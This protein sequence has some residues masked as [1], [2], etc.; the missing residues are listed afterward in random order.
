[1]IQVGNKLF[2]INE[3]RT[4]Q[5]H[6]TP[7]EVL[8]HIKS[9][10]QIDLDPCGNPWS[11]VEAKH[12]LSAHNN[13]NGLEISWSSYVNEGIVY[14][15]PPFASGQVINWVR[16]TVSEGLETVMLTACDPSTKWTR[17]TIENCNVHVDLSKR[18]AFIRGVGDMGAM[19]PTRLWYWGPD[20]YLFAHKFQNLGTIRIFDR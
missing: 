10:K 1:M 7:S 8:V 4:N 18:T 16:K 5:D 15:N 12:N 11:I 2:G 3:V 19:Q 6:N 17:E 13:E 20:K 14:I 9:F